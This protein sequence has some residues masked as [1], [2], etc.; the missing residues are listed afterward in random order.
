M[1]L[2]CEVLTGFNISP[3]SYIYDILF[4]IFQCCLDFYMCI[5]LMRKNMS[6]KKNYYIWNGYMEYKSKEKLDNE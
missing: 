1:L 2:S 5:L 3:Y 4:Y 6:G